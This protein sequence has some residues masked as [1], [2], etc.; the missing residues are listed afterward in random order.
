MNKNKDSDGKRKCKGVFLDIS[1][2]SVKELQRLASM[3]DQSERAS[4]IFEKCVK[5]EGNKDEL[6]KTIVSITPM[7]WFEEL[8]AAFC[9]AFGVPGS[10]ITIPGIICLI[11][12]LIGSYQQAFMCGIVILIPLIFLP[13]PFIEK[14]LTSW[15]AIQILKYFSFKVIFEQQIKPNHPTILVAP[16]HGVFP[17]GLY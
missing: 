13:V 16:P 4:K 3:K 7:T 11:G 8:S 14:S 9:F 5:V 6:S 10:V 1:S 2:I 17:F 15:I 12:F